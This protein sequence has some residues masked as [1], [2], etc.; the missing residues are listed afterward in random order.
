VSQQRCPIQHHAEQQPDAPALIQSE[1][2]VSYADY[3]AAIGIAVT[4]LRAAGV[5][6][7]STV[8]LALPPGYPALVILPALFRLGAIAF[9]LDPRFPE[10][11]L[12]TQLRRFECRV[13]VA[14]DTNLHAGA[15]DLRVLP[16]E[17]VLQGP[18]D[19]AQ[20]SVTVNLDDPA[21]M[22]L[23]SGSTGAPKAA[24]H[25]YGNHYYN[26]LR[27][28]TNLPLAP[29]DRWL[30]SLPLHHVA[31]IGVLFRTTLA[32]AAMVLPGPDEALAAC[33]AR[34]RATHVSLVATQLYRLLQYPEGRAA[35]AGCKAILLGGSAISEALLREAHTAGLPILTSYGMTEMAT[36]VTTTAPGDGL[37]ALLT[38][39]RPLAE[40][41]LRIAPSGE[42]QVRGETLFLGYAAPITACTGRSPKTAGSPPATSAV[43]T[44]PA[45]SASSAARTTS[46]SPAARTSSLKKLKPSSARS[47]ASSASSSS[48][49]TTPSSACSPSP[50]RAWP[51]ARPPTK[52]PCAP[53]S[54]NN[55]P[56]SSS[57]AASTPGP[58]T[59]APATI[60]HNAPPSPT[61]HSY[62]N[63]PA[64]PISPTRIAPK[65]S[66]PR[67][68]RLGQI[69]PIGPIRPKC[70]SVL[71][72][73]CPAKREAAPARRCFP[74]HPCSSAFIRG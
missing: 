5:E 13:I 59:S 40:G 66:P 31:G 34:H 58:K 42:I 22:I 61:G 74:S 28:N 2:T 37:D 48:P 23:T 25:A 52:T 12:R 68:I 70:H 15:E 38:S 41:I 69:G 30:M 33:I 1:G 51:T 29:G 55:S 36:Q 45:A 44:T 54:P 67:R 32:G 27:S 3:N 73:R 4:Q 57:P 65:L 39:G 53:P 64:S 20:V 49:W 8:A 18:R 46:S 6:R 17:A 24:V 16:V 14:M 62:A 9:P 43:W 21:T 72:R 56:A 71:S 11:Y 50:S 19:A 7:G 26:A 47:P 63:A 10:A 60:N 35:L